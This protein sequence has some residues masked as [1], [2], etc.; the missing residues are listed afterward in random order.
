VSQSLKLGQGSNRGLAT[1][2]DPVLAG[3]L[4]DACRRAPDPPGLDKVIEDAGRQRLAAYYLYSALF[5]EL[6]GSDDLAPD[7][8][9]HELAEPM[10]R[11]R[12]TRFAPRTGRG[13]DAQL[14]QAEQATWRSPGRQPKFAQLLVDLINGG[15]FGPLCGDADRVQLARGSSGRDLDLEL[16]KGRRVVGMC[17]VQDHWELVAQ[18][19][20][21]MPL[22]GTP[23]E[24]ASE[25]ASQ[26][27]VARQLRETGIAH[28]VSI[29]VDLAVNIHPLGAAA[30][31]GTRLVRSRIQAGQDEAD[32]LRQLGQELSTL[33][34]EAARELSDMAARRSM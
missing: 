15:A 19:L 10:R 5:A 29:S 21:G 12:L 31:L 6:I 18:H 33:G 24:T 26:H 13:L 1:V 27:T 22:G 8:W 17:T 28:A 2:A 11:L 32:A 34:A 3:L 30:G 14:T 4:A 7:R 23:A 16:I 20:A 9:P 25:P